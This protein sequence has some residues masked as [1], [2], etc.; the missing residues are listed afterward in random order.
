MDDGDG[1]IDDDH[2]GANCNGFLCFVSK[3]PYGID[4]NKNLNRAKQATP[5]ATS[6][7]QGKQ[8]L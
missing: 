8:L 1:I 6:F 2:S 7:L 5:L 3:I 4:I